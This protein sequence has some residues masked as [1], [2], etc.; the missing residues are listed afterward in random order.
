VRLVV[1]TSVLIGEL[2]RAQGREGLAD[3]RLE[4]FLPEEMWGEAQVELLWRVRA[5]A[6]K[7]SLAPA[8]AAELTNAC[9]AAIEANVDVIDLL[10][11]SA[12]EHEARFRSLRDP[13]EWPLVACSLALGA[14][15][16]SNDKDFLGTGIPTWTTQTLQAWLDRNPSSDE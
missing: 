7:R 13:K 11:Y 15:V 12:L 16:W 5:F 8:L 9:L 14:G 4:L 1:D 3:T 6:R 10:V 2:L